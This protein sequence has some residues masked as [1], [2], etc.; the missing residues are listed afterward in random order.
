MESA[1]ADMIFTHRRQA[2]PQLLI[3]NCQL[4]I[5]HSPTGFFNA[6]D[7][8]FISKLSEAD[9]AYTELAKIGMRPA[10]DLASVIRA[11]TE[12]CRVFLLDFHGCFGHNNSLLTL[13]TVRP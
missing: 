1:G 2:I 9:T 7:F 6:G 13:Q 5:E 12:L 11:G 8:A 4:L 10:A 3:I